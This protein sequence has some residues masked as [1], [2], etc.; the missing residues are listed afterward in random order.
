MYLC[1]VSGWYPE[2]YSWVSSCRQLLSCPPS[3]AVF[4]QPLYCW[5]YG[6][7]M[8]ALW[9]YQMVPDEWHS[10]EQ[11][12]SF[13]VPVRCFRVGRVSLY[14]Q[15]WNVR[16]ELK[17][18][19]GSCGQTTSHT[20]HTSNSSHTTEELMNWRTI[21][22]EECCL[23]PAPGYCWFIEQIFLSIVEPTSTSYWGAQRRLARSCKSRDIFGATLYS[24]VFVALSIELKAT[25]ISDGPGHGTEVMH[26]TARPAK[27]RTV[28]SLYARRTKL[29]VF[30]S[31][32]P[33]LP[34]FCILPLLLPSLHYFFKRMVMCGP[35]LIL[36]M[37]TIAMILL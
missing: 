17:P 19:S 10:L 16:T 2:Q 26:G 30:P 18:K 21:P 14:L 3:P 15:K 8:V 13:V 29:K 35:V 34:L 24:P 1:A 9:W 37:M 33:Q 22:A 31:F 23:F 20:S 12:R 36:P 32:I 5:W 25:A 4:W 28:Q 6:G 27:Q 7:M 11:F